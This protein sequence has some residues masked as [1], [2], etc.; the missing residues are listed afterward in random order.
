MP[1]NNKVKIY[2]KALVGVILDKKADEKKIVEN[3]VKLLKKTGQEKRVKEILDLAE[4]ML[5]R[6][7]EKKKIVFEVAR[8]LTSENR[9][10]LK[11]FAR[12]GDIVKE[13]I[14][15][16]LVAGVKITVNN[17]KQFDNSMLNKLNNIL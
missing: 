8:R 2:A 3:F 10:L 1:K 11:Q 16:N 4:D 12:E 17:E 13:K 6:K 15:H 9:A 5:L 14:N 7:Q